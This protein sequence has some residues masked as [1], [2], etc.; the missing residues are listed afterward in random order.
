MMLVPD[1]CQFFFC[2]VTTKVE[3]APETVESVGALVADLEKKTVTAGS[4]NEQH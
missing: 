4:Q 1:G 3:I 2:A